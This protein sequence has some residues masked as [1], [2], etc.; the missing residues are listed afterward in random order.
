MQLQG[1]K[2]IKHREGIEEPLEAF[3]KKGVLEIFTKFTRK[4]L[5]QSLR[6]ANLLKERPWNRCFPLD[7]LK[8]FGAPLFKEHLRTTASGGMKTFFCFSLSGKII[9][10]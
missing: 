2:C 9:D 4:H 10:I 7:F 3:S 1:F 5:C 6:P 8:F